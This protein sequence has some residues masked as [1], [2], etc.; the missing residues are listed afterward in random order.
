MKPA[1]TDHFKLKD[2]RVNSKKTLL[3]AGGGTGGHVLAGV[4][5]ADA[6]KKKWGSHASILFIGAKGG[7]EEKLVPKAGYLLRTLNLGSL[8]RVS[9]GRRIKTLLQLPI[10]LLKSLW[11]LWSFKPQF[12]IGVGGYA[13]GPVVLMG[14]ILSFF[15]ILSVKT[16]IL[17]QNSIPGFTNRVLGRI[18]HFV[19]TAFPGTEKQFK[20]KKVLLTGNPIRS[21]LVPLPAAN[22]SPFTIFVFG[23]SQGAKGMNSL[24]LDA[25]PFLVDLKTHIKWIHQTGEIDFERVKAAHQQAGT[26]ARIEKFIDDMLGAYRET[27]LLICRSG[28][29]T[30]SEI[31][32]VGR[33]AIFIP[34]PTAADNHQEKNARVF[35]DAGAG[36]FLSQKGSKGEDLAQIVRK[37]IEEPQKIEVAEQRVKSFFK[38]HAAESLIRGLLEVEDLKLWSSGDLSPPL[39]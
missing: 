26:Q 5:I 28:S 27:S 35:T 39:N 17:E 19:F 32:A 2:E 21:H 23:G 34:L 4:A 13:S 12:I 9:L 29:S 7:L 6:W 31:A 36:F 3:I 16:S 8:N 24:V 38:A 18:S 1:I 22:R 30:L 10:S 37:L 20:G 15:K 33:A 25:L 14:R 11:I